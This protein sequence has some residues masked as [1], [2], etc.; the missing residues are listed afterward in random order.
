MA[1]GLSS[2]ALE[3]VARW[4]AYLKRTTSTGRIPADVPAPDGAR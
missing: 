3:L 1:L 2:G 4:R